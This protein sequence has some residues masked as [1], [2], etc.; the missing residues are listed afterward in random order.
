[1]TLLARASDGN[2]V[3]G[4]NTAHSVEHILRVVTRDELLA[5]LAR[6][7]QEYRRSFERLVDLQERVRG[8]L[9]SVRADAAGDAAADLAV[10]LAP[11]ERRQRSIASSVN[12]IRQQF[13]QILDQLTLNGMDTI[14]ETTRLDEQII[15][16]LT[17]LASRSLP[18]AGDSIR[19]WSRT[20]DAEAPTRADQLQVGVVKKMRFVLAN[21]VQWEGYHEVVTMLNDIIRLQREL[22]E[23]S[24]DVVAQE[25]ADI[26]DK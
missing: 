24:K 3:S 4:P 14:D 12:V 25:A 10:A 18:E 21:M 11:I 7:E 8:E 17:E 15:S 20:P 19:R 22:G 23:E 13:Q 16:P 9:L 1:L 2:D 6:K 26:F 5:E